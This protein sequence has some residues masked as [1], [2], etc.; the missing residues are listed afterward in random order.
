MHLVNRLDEL[1]LFQ[2]AVDLPG[3]FGRRSVF[4]DYY[5]WEARRHWH[6]TSGGLKALKE[7][8]Y[9]ELLRMQ[10]AWEYQH[11]MNWRIN[12][13]SGMNRGPPDFF[14]GGFARRKSHPK[15][16]HRGTNSTTTSADWCQDKIRKLRVAIA[17]LS[18]E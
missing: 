2:S 13:E 3:Q 4:T 9:E 1:N 14:V 6:L 8:K 15:R 12:Q 11:P 10:E 7:R 18:E 17:D 16:L 5:S